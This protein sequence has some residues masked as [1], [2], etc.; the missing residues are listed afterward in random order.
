MVCSLAIYAYEV[1]P[2][3]YKVSKSYIRMGLGGE[4]LKLEIADTEVLREQGL[5]GHKP[6]GANEGMLFIFP[7]DDQHQF[8]MKDML[9]PI[10]IVWFDSEYRIID[11]RE[12]ADPNSYPEIFTPKSNARYVIELP[13]GFFEKYH[14][15]VGNIL[16]ILK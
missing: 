2:G 1:L 15:K 12:R 14:L 11:V 6:L 10:D 3:T 5:S 7:N 4:T 8:W 16:E 13:A 9:F